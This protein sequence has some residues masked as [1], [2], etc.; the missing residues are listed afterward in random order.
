[1]PQSPLDLVIQDQTT[2][3]ITGTVR[4]AIE[5]IG[6]EIA[7][8]ILSDPDFREALHATV[9]AQSQEILARLTSPLPERRRP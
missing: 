9:K 8:E 7:K 6:E 5:K 2:A 3:S 1:M 4:I